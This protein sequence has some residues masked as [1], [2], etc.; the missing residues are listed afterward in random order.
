MTN[1]SCLIVVADDVTAWLSPEGE[2]ASFMC[3]EL[4]FRAFEIAGA[5]LTD[6]PAHCSSPGMLFRTE[7]LD[8]L[9]RLV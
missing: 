3:S 9:G 2:D 1:V 5:P 4:V 8:C 6:K 7:R